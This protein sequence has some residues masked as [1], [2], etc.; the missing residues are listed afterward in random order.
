VVVA[1]TA[2]TALDFLNAAR[3]HATVIP[4]L[5]LDTALY[6]PAP[7]RLPGQFGRNRLKGERLPC[8]W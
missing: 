1:D 5:R 2:F 6:A 7:Q 8:A 4:R 3:R